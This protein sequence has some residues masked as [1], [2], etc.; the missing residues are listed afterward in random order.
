MRA[1]CLYLHIHQP[2]RY[3]EYSFFDISNSSDYYN[4]E[5]NDRESNERIFR[6]VTEKSY[7]PMLSLLEKNIDRH[8]NFKISFSITGT[9]LEQAAK[10]APDLIETVQ[11]MV[12]TGQVEIIDET[13]Y[14]SLAYFY[15]LDEFESQVKKHHEVIEKIFGVSPRI[16]RNTELAYNDSLAKWAEENGYNGILAEGWDKVLGWR[17]P[18]YVYRPFGCS[19]IKLLL[20]NYRL[21][22]DIAFR[23]S[24]RNWSEWPLTV[25][26]YQNWINMDCIHGNLVNLFMDFE[27]FGE[28]QWKDT[29]IFDFLN[30]FIESWLKE[31]ENRFVT[32][33]EACE[34][35][36]PVDEVSMPE[37]VTWAD[38]ERDLSAWLSNSMQIS[39]MD[40]LYSLRE[41]IINSQDKKL[42]SDWE[43][44]TTSDHPYSMCTK[45]WHDG[46][47]HAYFSAYASP[48]ESFMYFMNVLRDIEY[49]LLE[50]SG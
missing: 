4:G 13:Y 15:S 46:D 29:G 22:D 21:S 11:R 36:E 25:E 34:L 38:T 9:W 14:H 20:K 17:S 27:T 12:K 6:K 48:Y 7:R 47:V 16:F 39:A 42:I 44:L 31:Y 10:W 5:Y 43:H 33:S 40:E 24:N 19:K 32:A 23:F 3:K 35:M 49:R 1:I 30:Q 41:Q 28:H 37:T 26:K 2:I 18:N 8:S 50:I 45:Y